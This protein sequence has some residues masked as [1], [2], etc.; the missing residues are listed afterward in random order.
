MILQTSLPYDVFSPRPLPGV[1]PLGDDPWLLVDDAYGA[2]M[3]E[4]ARLLDTRRAAVLDLPQVGRAAADELLDLVLDALPAG[5][6][7]GGDSVMRPDGVHLTLER[8][9][10][11]GTLGQLVQ[12]DLCL[13]ER[14]GGQHVLT[15]A[16][17]C[18]PASWR[19]AEKILR[20]LDAIHG[21]VHSYDAH[22]ARRVQRLFDG[23]QVGRPVWRFNALWYEDPAL[24]QPRAETEP[25]PLSDPGTAP[26]LRSERQC[27]LRLPR[28]RA[29]VFSIHTFVVAR[30][31]SAGSTGS[32]A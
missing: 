17:L 12:E 23:L 13:L 24:H 9:D 4:R 7:R 5:F 10:P 3:A 26:Y 19:L 8:D 31:I 18:F 32:A 15:G 6:E 11:L 25:R 21:P 27:L 22:M 14:I 29:V 2:Q 28:T 1:R 20:P 30:G 16:V